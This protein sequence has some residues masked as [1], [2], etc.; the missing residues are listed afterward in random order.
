[1]LIACK[2]EEIYFPKIQDFEE[3]T[4]GKC[5]S[6]EIFSMEIQVLMKLQWLIN[7]MTIN[8]YANVF[9]MNWDRYLRDNPLDL[10]IIDHHFPRS[11]RPSS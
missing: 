11:S 3:I 2:L 10:A 4:D 8:G 6:A 5:S 9:M 7:P 1:L